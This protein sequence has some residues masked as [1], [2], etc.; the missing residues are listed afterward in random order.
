MCNCK[1]VIRKIRKN[2][3]KKENEERE[4]IEKTNLDAKDHHPY[5][6]Q[7]GSTRVYTCSK[8]IINRGG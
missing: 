3:K 2:K 7:V 5:D 4:K 1:S 8:L 6:G